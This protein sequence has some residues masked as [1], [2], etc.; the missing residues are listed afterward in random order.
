MVQVKE[1]SISWVAVLQIIIIMV[2][3]GVLFYIFYPKY[4]HGF[5]LPYRANKITGKVEYWVQGKWYVL[6]NKEEAKAGNKN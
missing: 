1:L 6:E 5:E 3:A 4:Q 2:T